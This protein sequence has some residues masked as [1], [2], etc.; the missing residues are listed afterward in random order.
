[1]LRKTGYITKDSGK[2]E[3]FG[4]GAKRDTRIGK[5]RYDLIPPRPL[6]R[7]AGVYERG[8]VKYGD[9]NWRKGMPFSRF[10]DSAIRHIIEWK[11][12]EED[13]LPQDEDHLAQAVWN[14]WAI[15]EFEEANPELNDLYELANPVGDEHAVLEKDENSR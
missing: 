2:R 14:L 7:L 9:N 8:S 11:E 5:G 4:T 6:K 3:S 12:R 13:D 10:L 15:M 1:M